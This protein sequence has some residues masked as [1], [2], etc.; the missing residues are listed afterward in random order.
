MKKITAIFKRVAKQSGGRETR[1]ESTKVK[2]VIYENKNILKNSFLN[3][4]RVRY[5]K[6]YDLTVN[7][8][9]LQRERERC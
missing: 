9:V 3:N 4:F 5:D 6:E 1:T 8:K 7:H 2:P